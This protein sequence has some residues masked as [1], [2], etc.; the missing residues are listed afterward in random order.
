MGERQ[1]DLFAPSFNRSVRLQ[2]TDDRITSDAGLILL[3]EADHRLGITESL[4]RRLYD[5]RDPDRIRYLMVE[6]VRERI[7]IFGDGI[8]GAR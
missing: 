5:L 2:A 3:R 7:Y 6:L 4:A 1:G 8:C